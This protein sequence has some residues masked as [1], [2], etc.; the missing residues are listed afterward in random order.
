MLEEMK[1]AVIFKPR[2]WFFLVALACA[3]LIGFALYKQHMDFVDP[4]PLCV[5]QRIA[6]I[7]IGVVALVA[8]LG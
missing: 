6:F 5:F 2:V 4:C 1:L 3:G 8:A 7:C